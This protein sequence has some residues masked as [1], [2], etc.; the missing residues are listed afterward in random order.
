AVALLVRQP[1]TA[2]SLPTD[3][4][5]PP[6][7]VPVT[8]ETIPP[9]V[10]PTGGDQP[11]VAPEIVPASPRGGRVGAVPGPTTPSAQHATILMSGLMPGVQVT[12]DGNV[13]GTTDRDGN[14]TVPDVAL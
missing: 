14:L 11:P 13:A 1:P 5:T 8:P 12:I 2:G 6:G 10:P 3:I 7:E 4:T 9:D